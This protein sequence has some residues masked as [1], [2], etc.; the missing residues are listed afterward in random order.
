MEFAR[1]W[2]GGFLMEHTGV[3][4]DHST[5]TTQ[6]LSTD[7]SESI[8]W[9][10]RAATSPPLGV[11]YF[12]VDFYLT[13]GEHAV[14]GFDY[15]SCKSWTINTLA[16]FGIPTCP[17]CTTSLKLMNQTDDNITVEVKV[18]EETRHAVMVYRTGE[19]ISNVVVD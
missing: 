6:Y 8:L 18:N 9:E 2:K 4:S 12:D 15:S 19:L 5:S 14:G 7:L 16:F 1:R 3:V 17:E 10:C 13:V 11:Y